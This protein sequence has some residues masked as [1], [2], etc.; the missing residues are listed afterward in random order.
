MVPVQGEGGRATPTERHQGT[1]SERK[2]VKDFD[3]I[4]LYRPQK[5]INMQQHYTSRQ[6]LL[7]VVCVLFLG[8]SKGISVLL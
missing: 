8:H 6:G 2:G 4:D 3:S 1:D 5:A 7:T